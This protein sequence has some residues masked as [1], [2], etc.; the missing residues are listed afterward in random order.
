M[1]YVGKEGEIPQPWHFLYI[2]RPPPWTDG[3]IFLKNGLIHVQVNDNMTCI[4][5][6]MIA[7]IIPWNLSPTF[8]T[9]SGSIE[10]LGWCPAAKKNMFA[11]CPL[12]FI[13]QLIGEN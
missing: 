7:A 10:A 6:A 2:V 12:I 4:I 3:E 13:S 9:Y 1:P 8:C 5:Q 11:L